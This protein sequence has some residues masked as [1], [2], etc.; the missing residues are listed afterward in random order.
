[1]AYIAIIVVIFAAFMAHISK[2]V[3]GE[4]PEGMKKGEVSKVGLL[5][6]IVLAATIL[7]MGLYLPDLL[8][9]GLRSIVDLFGGA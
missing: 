6:M 4:P 7:I 9:D 2:M 1:M 5:P 8:S 3:F